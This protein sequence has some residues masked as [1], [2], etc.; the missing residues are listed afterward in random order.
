MKKNKLRASDMALVGMFAALMSVGANIT[1]FAPFLQI[2]GIP[3]SMQPFFC[4]L[5]GL[6]L[7]RRLGALAMIIYALIGFIG[8]PVF[9]NFSGGISALLKGSGGFIIAFIPAAY[10]AGWMTD[11]KSEPNMSDFFTA[12]LIG[13]IIIYLIGV[14]YMYLAFTNWLDTPLT[15]Q[16]TWGMMTGFFIKDVFFSILLAALSSK[17]YQAV[18]KGANVNKNSAY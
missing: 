6:L 11:R 8:A 12:S 14:N 10:V 2:G 9:A 1:S 3:L 13:T 16:A 18:R 4:L 7:G 5:A 17:I 15:Y